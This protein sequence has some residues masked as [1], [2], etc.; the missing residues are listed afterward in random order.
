MP[1]RGTLRVERPLSINESGGN[2]GTGTTGYRKS[3]L[4]PERGVGHEATR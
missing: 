4:S 3:P 1:P 2:N